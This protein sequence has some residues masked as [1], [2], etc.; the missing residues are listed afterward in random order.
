MRQGVVNVY[1]ISRTAKRKSFDQ[2]LAV[3][4][5]HISDLSS[6]VRALPNMDQCVFSLGSV[7]R[8]REASESACKGDV[9]VYRGRDARERGYIDN[10]ALCFTHSRLR[11]SEFN[12][13]A[14]VFDRTSCY[15]VL[16]PCPERLFPVIDDLSEGVAAFV[17]RGHKEKV[18]SLES[19]ISHPAYRPPPKRTA[20]VEPTVS[21]VQVKYISTAWKLLFII[22]SACRIRAS[23]G[24][25]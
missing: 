25:A 8:S 9:I 23:R 2:L 1:R 16:H 6:Y 12:R 13:C 10:V 3:K 7:T 14:V 11:R 15:G 5:C 21:T 22:T 18:D 20:A 17:C 4:C 19:V 24:R